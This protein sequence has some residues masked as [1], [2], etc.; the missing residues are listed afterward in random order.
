MAGRGFMYDQ[1]RKKRVTISILIILIMCGFGQARA[2][3]TEKVAITCSGGAMVSTASP[4]ATEVGAL[5]LRSGGNAVDAAV[6]VGFALAVTHPTAGNLGGGGFMLVR[7]NSREV[8]FIDF[9]EKAPLAACEKMYLDDNDSV[10]PGMSTLGHR[11]AGVPGTVEGM[12]LAWEK[13]GSMPWRDLLEPAI[14]LAEKGFTVSYHLASSLRRLKKYVKDYPALK[15]YFHYSGRCLV[16]GDTLVQ[17]QLAGTLRLIAAEGPDAFYRG[18]I[19]SLIIREMEKG[20]GLIT[21]EDLLKYKAVLRDP[22]IGS[23]RGYEILSAPPPSSGGIVLIE[24]LNILEGFDMGGED[25]LSEQSV[26]WMIEA[27][28][29]AYYDRAVYLGDPDFNNIPVSLL[30]SKR[31]AEKLRFSIGGKAVSAADI[32]SSPVIA[33]ESEETTHYSVLDADGCAVAVTTTLNSGYGSKVV[34]EGAGFLLNNEMDDFSIKPGVPNIYGLTGGKANAIAPEKR[35]LS[36]MAPT[37]ILRGDKVLMVLGTPGG[38]TIITTIAQ[39]IVDIIDFSMSPDEAVA[40][41]RYHHQWVPDLV[42][43]EEGVFPA[44][45]RAGLVKR[46]HKLKERSVIG[47][48]QLIMVQEGMICGV[49]DPRHGGKPVGIGKMTDTTGKEKD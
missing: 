9:R 29:R 4:A 5:I 30:I 12:Y 8:G 10:I 16:M 35:M 3:C 47:D 48:A 26:H 33:D 25:F 42:Y 22:V 23:Y 27:E 40:S 46:G 28:K 44:G 21:R 6:A 17:P 11:A 37:I 32:G 34:V 13:Y 2:A 49:S 31:Y 19:A 1:T 20:E 15:K 38:S 14:K 18:R 39:L 45:L 7:K 41:G 24:I 36:S 43:F